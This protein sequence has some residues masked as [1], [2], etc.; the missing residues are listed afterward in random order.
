MDDNIFDAIRKWG[1][2]RNLI[3]GGT[4]SG[5]T[6]K[7]FEETGELARGLIEDDQDKIVDAI[8][9]C[10]VVLTLLAAQKGTS[11]EQCIKHA[12][13]QIKDRKGKMVDGIFVKNAE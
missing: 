9:D 3:N 1:H 12:Y 11:I 10:V 2:D 7:F 6:E 13:D 8:G 4:V 5:Q